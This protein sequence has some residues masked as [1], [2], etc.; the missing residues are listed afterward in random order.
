M[1]AFPRLLY[2]GDGEGPKNQKHVHDED[3]Q[4]DAIK[5]GWRMK[6][7]PKGKV[8]AK[9]EDTETGHAGNSGGK[10]PGIGGM[11]PKQAIALINATESL[12]DLIAFEGEETSRKDGARANVVKAIKTKRKKL[13]Q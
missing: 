1:S 12:E 3:A 4:A 7:F 5:H 2:K 6:K 9:D 8:Q 11:T 13:G 10:T